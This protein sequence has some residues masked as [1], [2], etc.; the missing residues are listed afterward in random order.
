MK[1]YIKAYIIGIILL[2]V[3]VAAVSLYISVRNKQQMDFARYAMNKIG[4]EMALKKKC[5][6]S[7]LADTKLQDGTVLKRYFT[8]SEISTISKMCDCVVAKSYQQIIKNRK[9]W[10]SMVSKDLPDEAIE[11]LQGI[12]LVTYQIC[13]LELQQWLNKQYE[14]VEVSRD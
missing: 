13:D 1:K 6:G 9:Q 5:L 12:L 3:G 8:G 7:S 2:F 4:G 10:E 11:G 14:T